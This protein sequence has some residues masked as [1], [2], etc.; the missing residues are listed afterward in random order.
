MYCDFYKLINK[1][2]ITKK[3]EKSIILFIFNLYSGLQQLK[4]FAD[5]SVKAY[6]K[7]SYINKPPKNMGIFAVSPATVEGRYII[8]ANEDSVTKKGSLEKNSSRSGLWGLM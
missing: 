8:G 1:Q 6:M 4:N 7:A 5:R 2:L 3:N